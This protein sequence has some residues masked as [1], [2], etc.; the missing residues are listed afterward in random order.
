V[1]RWFRGS[2]WGLAGLLRVVEEHPRL[3]GAQGRYTGTLA[4]RPAGG[5]VHVQPEGLAG[6]LC[7][8][9]PAGRS[10]TAW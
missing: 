4:Q 9:I 3:I 6:E 8:R 10:T 2:P 1:L 7:L 5:R